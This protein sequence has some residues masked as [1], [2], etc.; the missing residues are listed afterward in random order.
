MLEALRDSAQNV[1][2]S[3]VGLVCDNTSTNMNAL[4]HLESEHPRLITANCA[5][6]LSD[7]VI[8]EVFRMIEA[9]LIFKM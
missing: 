2:K 8:E 7:L 6:H 3:Y 1:E 5:A 9:E 4:G